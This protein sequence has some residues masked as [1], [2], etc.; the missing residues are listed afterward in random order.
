MSDGY[1]APDTG[2]EGEHV[3]P[4]RVNR[5]VFLGGVGASLATAAVAFGARYP[6]LGTGGAASP[7]AVTRSDAAVKYPTNIAFR[8]E[9]TAQTAEITAVSLLYHPVGSP[10]FRRV[11]VPIERGKKVTAD[12]PLDTQLNFLFPGVDVEYRWLFTLADGSELRTD[13]TSV[14]Y[15][16]TGKPWH[17]TQNGQ[18]TLWWYSGDDAFGKDAVDTAARAADNIKKTFGVMGDRPIRVLIYEN[19]RD[20]RG[21]LPPNSV[22][23]IAGAARKDLGLILAAIAPGRSAGS[24]IRRVIPHE[25][26]HQI[27]YQASQNPYNELPLWLDEG[28][29]VRN[30]ETTDIRLGPILRDALEQDKLI[31]LRALNSPF[32]LD[33][34]QA[35]LSYAES[36]SVVNY[37]VNAFRPQTLGNLV[38][39]FKDGLSYDQAMQQVLKESIED[40]ENDWKS[41]LRYGGDQGRAGM[42]GP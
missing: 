10:S 42:A 20:L 22:E 37:I 21:A 31:P 41:S 39:S 1:R 38:S 4:R 26:S 34:S 14:F 2:S 3:S 9:A 40:L 30:Q 33:E 7:V 17:K 19:S 36:E 24:E 32:P 28:L 15:M 13:S 23:W 11:H 25:I 12:Y 8:L 35:I 27:T 6:A 5:R 29:A 18:I 16:D